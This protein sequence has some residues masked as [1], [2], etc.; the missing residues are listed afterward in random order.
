MFW[1]ELYF[2]V[3]CKLLKI[4]SRQTMHSLVSHNKG[5]AYFSLSGG[6][7]ILCC[8]NFFVSP[9]VEE[10]FFLDNDNTGIFHVFELRIG[11]N[12]FDHRSFL[13]L[14]KLR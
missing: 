13:S 1:R 4:V 3:L 14:L 12:E 7:V 8:I 11:M 9:L 10:E 2:Y 6:W 5:A